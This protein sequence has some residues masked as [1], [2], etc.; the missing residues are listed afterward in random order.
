MR[1]PHSPSST[2][3]L[4]FPATWVRSAPATTQRTRATPQA[5]AALVRAARHRHRTLL[6]QLTLLV[7]TLRTILGT[8]STTATCGLCTRRTWTPGRVTYSS[9]AAD[10]MP[11]GTRQT[12][13]PS[14]SA[15]LCPF[16]HLVAHFV[17]TQAR[18]ARQ[19]HIAPVCWFPHSQNRPKKLEMLDLPR[20]VEQRPSASLLSCTCLALTF[21]APC[22]SSCGP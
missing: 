3:A 12:F 5:T 1:P 9:I 19:V 15:P 8:S 7:P 17:F 10:P 2:T 16:S 18:V 11:C 13:L 21:S 22:L 4:P 6:Q 20:A 14:A